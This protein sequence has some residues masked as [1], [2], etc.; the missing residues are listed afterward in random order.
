MVDLV[1]KLQCCVSLLE[2]FQAGLS[3]RY[4]HVDK[5]S[6]AT[7]SIIEPAFAKR[8]KSSANSPVVLGYTYSSHQ[9]LSPHHLATRH[10]VV[11]HIQLI[12][13]LMRTAFR[14]PG[15]TIL[16]GKYSRVVVVAY[17]RVRLII[18]S[19]TQ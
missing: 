2:D 9:T 6:E 1:S 10:R 5:N 11:G 15:R 12:S 13:I 7:D 8:T 18:F 16:P 17:D 19:P 3:N 14:P 4:I